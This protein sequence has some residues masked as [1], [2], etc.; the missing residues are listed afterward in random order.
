MIY[1]K[2]IVWG[3]ENDFVNSIGTM[4]PNATQEDVDQIIKMIN[5]AGVT[6]GTKLKVM[7]SNDSDIGD[8]SYRIDNLHFSV[9]FR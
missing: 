4:C 6:E 3:N 7:L 5:R 1:T 2:N 8:I 9:K